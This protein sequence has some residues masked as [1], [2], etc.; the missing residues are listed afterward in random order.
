M[1]D[2]QKEKICLRKP[3]ELTC[4][5]LAFWPTWTWYSSRILDSSDE[6]W[7]LVA[8]FTAVYFLF[9]GRAKGQTTGDPHPLGLV[10]LVVY[11]AAFAFAPNLVLSMIVILTLWF[12]LPGGRSLQNRAGICGLL[13]IS[14]PL[15]PSLNFYGG[16]P[17]RLITSAGATL[18]LNCFGLGA[19]Q[20]G[21]MLTV[22]NRLISIDAPCSGISMLWASAYVTLLLATLFK[23]QWKQTIMLGLGSSIVVILGNI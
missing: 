7:G 21:T 23:L 10:L 14:L 15:I 4:L 1:V 20:D 22:Q 2:V 19:S 17:L 11:I 13:F 5:I 8:L 9:R 16:Y 18:M 6:P 12:V 3:I